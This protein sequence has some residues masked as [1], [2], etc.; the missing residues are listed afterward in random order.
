M[1]STIEFSRDRLKVRIFPDRNQ[2]G[3]ACA[4]EAAAAL[5]RTIADKGSANVI[6][7]S[8][9]SQLELLNGLIAETGVEWGKV[10]ALH[11]DEYIGLPADAPQSFGNYLR[12]RLFTRLPFAE[13]FYLDGNAPDVEA[14]C[15]RYSAVLRQ[16]PVDITFLGIGENGHI[17]FNDPSIADFNDPKLVKMLPE[18]DAVGRLQQ[19]HD[20]WFA[21]LDQVPYSALTLTVPALVAARYVY[22]CVPGKTKQQIVRRTLQGPIGE[23]CP[24]T[25]IR[26]HPAAELYLDADSAELLDIETLAA[27]GARRS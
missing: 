4:A 6:F 16:H 14:E 7:A 18:L 5:R 11:M 26:L 22:A 1:G 24:G 19:V 10:R 25:V 23:D 3:R 27:P 2:M 13:V 9:P 21:S 17:A 15:R 8:A 12:T 20:G